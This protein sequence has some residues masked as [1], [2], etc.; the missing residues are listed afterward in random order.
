MFA[1]GVQFHFTQANQDRVVYLPLLLSGIIGVFVV[2]YFFFHDF[3]DFTVFCLLVPGAAKN[4]S[5]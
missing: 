1:Q 5:C 3:D 4:P 2:V